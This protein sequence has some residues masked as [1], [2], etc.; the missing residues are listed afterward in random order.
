MWT[1]ISA[2]VSVCFS[3]W[4]V[5]E[6]IYLLFSGVAAHTYLNFC[7]V[8]LGSAGEVLQEKAAT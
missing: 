5:E 3:L 1:L 6:V 7:L 2:K 4:L 8:W